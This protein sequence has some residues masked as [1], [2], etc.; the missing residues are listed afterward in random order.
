MLIEVKWVLAFPKFSGLTRLLY[1]AIIK[2]N[3]KHASP[4][5]DTILPRQGIQSPPPI[6]NVSIN[7]AAQA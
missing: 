7:A 5:Y 4:E 6:Q 3:R 2:Q 1:K